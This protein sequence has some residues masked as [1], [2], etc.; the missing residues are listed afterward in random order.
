MLEQF[1]KVHRVVMI[2]FKGP[3]KSSEAWQVHYLDA[4]RGNNCLENLEYVTPSQNNQYSHASLSRKCSGPARSKPVMF[5]PTVSTEW[6]TCPS[7]TAAAHLL[8]ISR[9]T[10]SRACHAMTPACDYFFRYKDAEDLPTEEWRPMVDPFSGA[11]VRGRQVS[12]LGRITST[13]GVIGVG[14]LQRVGYRGTSISMHGQKRNLNVHQLVAAAFVGLP[15]PG[16][17]IHVNHKDS[18]KSN[19]AASNLEYVTAAENMAHF[20]ANSPETQRRRPG[21]KPVWS[22]ALGSDEPWKWHES[23]RSAARELGLS[24]GNISQC[25]NGKTRSTGSYEFQFA[26][27]PES[28]PLPGEEWRDVNID[29]LQ[30]DR[31]SR[32]WEDLPFPLRTVRWCLPGLYYIPGPLLWKSK[33]RS[34]IC[35]M[36]HGYVVSCA[37]SVKGI[38]LDQ[39]VRWNREGRGRRW[40]CLDTTF[41]SSSGHHSNEVQFELLGCKNDLARAEN[42]I[43]PSRVCFTVGFLPPVD[44]F[45]KSTIWTLYLNNVASVS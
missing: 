6:T 37:K 2:T 15:P 28:H 40:F 26:D 13:S 27:M 20:W 3:P 10:V 1:W 33:W 39:K 44:V 42:D 4:D 8:G 22:R 32:L 18:N 5:R 45:E 41:A 9:R 14:S 23:A 35:S 11:L 19:N 43:G 36:D 30:R 31:W 29:A 12:S 16:P 34:Q 7:G 17:Y 38:A 24:S 25:V 21:C